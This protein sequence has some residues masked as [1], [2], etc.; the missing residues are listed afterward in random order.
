MGEAFSGRNTTVRSSGGEP[1]WLADPMT[2]N[3]VVRFRDGIQRGYEQAAGL[4]A[5]PIRSHG[6]RL[7]PVK[8]PASKGEAIAQGI[9]G[10]LVGIDYQLFRSG[11]LPAELVEHARPDGSVA[12]ADGGRLTI[13]LPAAAD[14]RSTSDA[15]ET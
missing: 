4:I 6:R 3:G 10:V 5:G 7:D 13:E 12:A 9:G 8:K 2:S 11:K 1:P 14:D 15:P